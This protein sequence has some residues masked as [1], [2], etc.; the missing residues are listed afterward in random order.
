MGFIGE[1]YKNYKYN[2][3]GRRLF[4]HI[5]I[6]QSASDIMGDIQEMNRRKRIRRK[7]SRRNRKK[8]MKRRNTR[9]EQKD[10]HHQ[11]H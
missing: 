7:R 4:P 5:S 8:R 11:E 3:N 6:E 10:G 9:E 2:S 1:W